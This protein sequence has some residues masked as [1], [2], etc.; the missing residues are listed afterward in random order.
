MTEAELR[1]RVE[2]RT[3]KETIDSLF[4]A[5]LLLR[6]TAKSDWLTLTP[7]GQDLL[8]RLTNVRYTVR[9]RSR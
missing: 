4:R 8:D 5:G 2:S 9:S 6:S 3:P 1:K 7:A